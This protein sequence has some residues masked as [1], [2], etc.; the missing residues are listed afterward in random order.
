MLDARMLDVAGVP[1]RVFAAPGTGAPLVFAQGG[2]PGVTPWVSGAHAWRDLPARFARDHAVRVI[3]LP[4]SGATGLPAGALTVDALV[5]HLAAALATLG[6]GP[7]HLVAHDLAGLLALHVALRAPH[8]VR[9]VTVVAS[10][11]AAPS[12]DGV[13]NLTFAHPPAPPWSRR[14]QRWALERIVYAHQAVD[15]ALVDACVQAAEGAPH[16]MAAQRMAAGEHERCFAPSLLR[17]KARLFAALR[18]AG[19]R[20]PVQVVWGSHDP[21]ASFDQGLWLFRAV[22][23]RQRATQFHVVNRAGALPFREDPD[24]FHQV[25]AA[26]AAGLAAEGA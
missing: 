3:E 10:S 4:G 5:D 22:A 23:A 2:V 13:A 6:T 16:R 7:A 20:V 18:D 24:A 9:A 19:I 15:A 21:L 25:V 17:A 12:G 1:T 14:A 26:F 11:A 8:L